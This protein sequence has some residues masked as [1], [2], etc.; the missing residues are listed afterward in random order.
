[1][2]TIKE[3]TAADDKAAIC[4]NILRALPNWFGIEESIVDYVAGVQ[5]KPFYALVGADGTVGFVSI[6]VHNQYT[7]EIYVMG[8]L[9][10]HHRQGLGKKIVETCKDYC[11]THGMEFLTVKTLDASREDAS[12]AKTRK[13]YEAMGFKPLEVFPTL[14]DPTNPCLFMAMYVGQF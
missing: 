1:M 11:R 10:S 8:I 12:Y 3:I 6:L 7:A 4:D 5:N 14:W 13:F 2:I 9:E